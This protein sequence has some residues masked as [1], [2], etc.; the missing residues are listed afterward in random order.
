VVALGGGSAG[1]GASLAW[2]GIGVIGAGGGIAIRYGD[3]TN[4]WF[5]GLPP[6]TVVQTKIV[7]PRAGVLFGFFGQLSAALGA[8]VTCSYSIYVNG[9]ITAVT[10]NIADPATTGNSGAL[11]A[12]VAAGDTIEC[13]G[14]RVAG[15][16]ASV[17]GMFTCGLL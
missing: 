13:V 5:A 1:G 10:F 11:S 3:N 8:G 12:P 9:V 14:A 4:T 17:L 2:A 15:V 6:T 16:P 7:A